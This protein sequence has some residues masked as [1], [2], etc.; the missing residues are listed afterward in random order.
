MNNRHNLSRFFKQTAR[1]ASNFVQFLHNSDGVYLFSN[2]GQAS[3]R[4]L[5]DGV[6]NFGLL[7]SG[8]L[9]FGHWAMQRNPIYTTAISRGLVAP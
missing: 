4:H 7:D 9:V 8:L 3:K 6:F 5:L 2:D 1:L